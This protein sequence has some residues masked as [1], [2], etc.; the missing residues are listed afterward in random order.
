MPAKY[1]MSHNYAYVS[2]PGGVADVAQNLSVA[3]KNN[4]AG[5]HEVFPSESRSKARTFHRFASEITLELRHWRKDVVLIFPNYFAFPLP[6]SST[7]DIVVVH[8]L[9]YK[10]FPQFHS[11]PKRLLLEASH[12]LAR[13]RAA[14]IV[15]ISKAT[16]GDFDRF[17]GLPRKHRVILN[18]VAVRDLGAIDARLT[19]AIGSSPYAIANFHH[20]P[21]KNIEKVLS[22]FRQMRLQYPELKLVLTGRHSQI[23]LL[24][25][26]YGLDDDSVVVSGFLPKNMVLQLVANAAFFVSLSLF[27]GFNMA[28]A[29]AAKLGR[30]LLL[31]NITVHRE[32]F[33]DFAFFV[34]PHIAEFPLSSFNE[35]LREHRSK[36][37]WK[38]SD[39]TEPEAVA[40][41]YADFFDEVLAEPENRA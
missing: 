16:E 29:E 20:Y 5:F 25:R 35:Y 22:F 39:A 26:Q 17:F 4:L 28:A 1:I 13:R 12:R 10:S 11:L 19:K 37:Y 6:G 32:L 34:D 2:N 18:P 30:P 7:R 3:F 38:F 9:Q 8:D 36:G 27:E 31:S 24:L 14:G 33:D 41:R 15:F 21:H 23:G 40:A